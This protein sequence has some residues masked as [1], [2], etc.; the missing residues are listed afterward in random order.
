MLVSIAVPEKLPGQKNVIKKNFGAFLTS[1]EVTPTGLFAT[2]L[3]S[4][5]S[6]CG[7]QHTDTN[8]WSILPFLVS[9]GVAKIQPESLYL[10]LLLVASPLI[11]G[12][13]ATT[14]SNV[15]AT[16]KHYVCTLN[17]TLA[18]HHKW[19]QR[20]VRQYTKSLHYKPKCKQ[21]PLWLLHTQQPHR[22]LLTLR[23]ITLLPITIHNN[24]SE[25]SHHTLTMK[26]KYHSCGI[27]KHTDRRYLHK[28]SM[29]KFEWP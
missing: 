14:S 12:Y 23:Y 19:L 9:Q 20:K 28:I 16:G 5:C 6:F 26:L 2:F 21:H 8:I 25:I 1:F 17:V 18:F 13:D 4:M 27:V 3:L 11:L 7:G 29:H 22:E 24:K 10:R 15:G